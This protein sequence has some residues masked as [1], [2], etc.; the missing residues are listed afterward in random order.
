LAAHLIDEQM[1]DI[2]G[3][4]P[5]YRNWT[6]EQFKLDN[7]LLVKFECKSG[8]IPCVGSIPVQ[9]ANE[10]LATIGRAR[11]YHELRCISA[12]ERYFSRDKCLFVVDLTNG[13]FDW[14]IAGEFVV[15]WI[16]HAAVDHAIDLNQKRISRAIPTPP[17]YSQQL[18]LQA[19]WVLECE[20]SISQGSAF[21]LNDVGLV[22]CEH[23]VSQ[24]TRLC[25]FHPATPQK[26]FKTR[27]VK[28][29]DAVDLA[30]LQLEVSP[31]EVPLSR[32]AGQSELHDHALVSGFPNYQL[33]D[34]GVFSPSVI[35]GTRQRSGIRRLLTNAPIVRGMSGGPVV[36]SEN[37]VIGVCVTGADR[38][39]S[40]D[41]TEDKSI[42]PIGA[43]D[44]L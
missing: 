1:P 43:I 16:N 32:F 41:D 18:I 36:G 13:G 14:D 3:D 27:V 2:R 23:V 17:Q 40:A 44:Q 19:L 30:V 24:A 28:A 9:V 5:D 29:N 38:L 33:G 20:E 42:I 34:L 8:G 10:I 26:K 21:W 7:I 35:I 6:C 4:F 37:K 25:A 11:K 15:D 22:T 31:P 39:A 12:L